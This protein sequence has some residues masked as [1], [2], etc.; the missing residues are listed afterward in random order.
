[1]KRFIDILKSKDQSRIRA[2]VGIL[3]GSWA[4]EKLKLGLVRSRDL[5]GG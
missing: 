5:K 1:M 2:T 4:I 3:G